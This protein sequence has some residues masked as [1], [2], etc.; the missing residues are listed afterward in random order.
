[1]E[2]NKVRLNSLTVPPTCALGA[3]RSVPQP[4]SLMTAFKRVLCFVEGLRQEAAH[5]GI[6]RRRISG[7]AA[8]LTGEQKNLVQR[9]AQV[10]VLH[11]SEL[12]YYLQAM[13][14]LLCFT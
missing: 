4:L 8:W 14:L 1:V 7:Q 2:Q 13:Q 6:F 10:A 3:P 9:F 12:I 5:D 11:S